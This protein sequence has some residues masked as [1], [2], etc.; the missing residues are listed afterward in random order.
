VESSILT[1]FGKARS[2]NG[3]KQLYLSGKEDAV[4][5]LPSPGDGFERLVTVNLTYNGRLVAGA[6]FT[7]KPESSPYWKGFWDGLAS[8]AWKIVISVGLMVI[9]GFFVPAQHVVTASRIILGVGVA[10]NLLEV[11]TDILKAY[12]ARDAMNALANE[13]LER[14]IE[15]LAKGEAE[16]AEECV[17]LAHRLRVEADATINN[18]GINVLSELFVDVTWDEVNIA[19]GWKEPLVLPGENRDYKVGYATGRVAGAVVLCMLYGA[20]YAMV[21]KI[22]AERIAGEP[23][24]VSQVLRLMARGIYN[25]ITPAIWDAVVLMR[26]K[27]GG[28]TSSVVDLL[29]GNKYSS[30]FGE[31]V[32]S[33][34]ED[35]K[36]E[37]P[38]VGD[39]LDASSGISKHVLENVPSKESSSR[40]LDAIGSIVENYSPEELKEKGKTIVRSIVSMWIKDGDE[41]IDSL[42]S[43]LSTNMK[44]MDKMD[45][46]ER[47]KVVEKI[48]ALEGILLKIDGDA[49]KEVGLRIGSIVDGYLKVKGKYD[50]DTAE[51]FIEL[52]LKNPDKLE[53]IV[54]AFKCSI[55]METHSVTLKRGSMSTIVLSERFEEGVYIV[56]VHWQYEGTS[57]V[58]EFPVSTKGSNVIQLPIR[59]ANEVLDLIGKN[60]DEA[61]V[62]VTKI[63][64]LDYRLF[65]PSS[66]TIGSKQIGLD[67]FN[68]RIM[69]GM[70]PCMYSA[71]A[72]HIEEIVLVKTTLE[73]GD[74]MSK[75]LTL[76][77]YS[78]GKVSTLVGHHKIPVQDIQIDA[79]NEAVT[80]TYVKDGSVCTPVYSLK[81]GDLDSAINKAFRWEEDVEGRGHIGLKEKLLVLLGYQAYQDF[82]EE[83]GSK[84]GVLV[85]FDN[86]RK[87]YTGEESI[88]VHVPEGAR[89]IETIVVVSIEEKIRFNL[90]EIMKYFAQGE[91]KGAA[92]SIGRVS[93]HIVYHKHLL[94]IENL[95]IQKLG[96]EG[97]SEEQIMDFKNKVVSEQL[98]TESTGQRVTD[99]VFRA[100]EA[101]TLG[102][103]TFRA[104]DIIIIVEIKGTTKVDSSEFEERF[105]NAIESLK[106]YINSEDYK[107]AK[108]GVAVAFG[109]DPEEMLWSLALS[110]E[111]S[112]PGSIGP[113]ENPR[114]EIFTREEL[115]GGG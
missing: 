101:I 90:H 85:E 11:G 106:G 43:W 6:R 37:F 91:V 100:Q 108:Y 3:W 78:D 25:W 114:I 93:E 28:F 36:G 86:G 109:F 112:Y 9:V 74:T 55:F 44:D 16:H 88:A 14:A 38:K 51:A 99:I 83:I 49:A 81:A 59:E 70:K 65:F 98:G 7:L 40:I 50:E 82:K 115:L 4:L 15:Y 31:A 54:E 10:M 113:F 60:I 19:F 94:E 62:K 8:Q 79:V 2:E 17:E 57:G 95:I 68:N 29:L 33:L 52:A 23:L 103:K 84:Y 64:L 77:F 80:L 39:T 34:L 75:P 45:P 35:T 107:T 66:F 58:A 48:R 30:R 42:N 47:L 102:K 53:S 87:A 72:D 111:L 46:L 32:G 18:L 56:R 104:G 105:S 97:V 63:S 1:V 76:V 26:G 73:S 71:E 92:T 21:T 13:T 5:L 110:N 61:T 20:F 41:A 96:E 69:L 22:K 24:S 89:K 27:I 12:E 67:L